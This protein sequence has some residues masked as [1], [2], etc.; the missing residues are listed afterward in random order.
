MS[1]QSALRDLFDR[2]ERVWHERHYDL[3]PACIAPHYI[4]HDDAGDRT[5]TREAYAAELAK[6]HRDRPDMRI[7]VYDHSLIGDRAW[8]RFTMKWTDHAAGEARSRAGMQA[9]RIEDGKLAETWVLLQ[10]LGSAWSDSVAQERWTSPP[11]GR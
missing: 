1:D 3:I 8:F 11:P 5:V 10:P 7:M 4:R 6:L 2:W 9:Y